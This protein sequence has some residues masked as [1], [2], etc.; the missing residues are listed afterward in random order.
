MSHKYYNDNSDPDEMFASPT[1]YIECKYKQA[2]IDVGNVGKTEGET[3]WNNACIPPNKVPQCPV[4]KD[5]TRTF[6]EFQGTL[7]EFEAR[8]EVA[9]SELMQCCRS[10]LWWDY[11]H[12]NRISLE[13][14]KGLALEIVTEKKKQQIKQA[15]AQLEEIALK[16]AEIDAKRK[17]EK[18]V[19]KKNKQGKKKGK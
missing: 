2:R 12:N 19:D 16:A 8:S 6:E 1:T 13:K 17:K 5:D 14:S 15:E 11:F 3:F 4:C 9:K 18:D 7:M 10:C